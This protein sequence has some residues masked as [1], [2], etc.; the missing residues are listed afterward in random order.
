[1]GRTVM[2]ARILL[3]VIFLVFGIDF[4]YPYLPAQQ[5]SPAGTAFLEALLGTGYLFQLVKIIE[6]GSA[7]LLITGWRPALGVALVAPIVLNIA[8]YHLILDPNGIMVGLL[9][10]ILEAFLLWAYRD[11]FMPLLRR[12]G[13]PAR[14]PTVAALRRAQA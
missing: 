13:L 6:M 11:A 10:A 8:L 2:I 14:S 5:A 12:S 3:G 1:M 4:L 7:I 9:I